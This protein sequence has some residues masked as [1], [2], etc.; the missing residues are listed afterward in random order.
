MIKLTGSYGIVRKTPAAVLPHVPKPILS[1]EDAEQQWRERE[2]E[3][4]LSPFWAWRAL[5]R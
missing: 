1:P 3:E 2:L 4:M 5:R